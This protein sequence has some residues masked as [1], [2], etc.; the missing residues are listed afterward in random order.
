MPSPFPGMDPYIEGQGWANFHFR[1]IAS[2]S[3]ALLPVLRPRYALVIEE[4]VYLERDAESHSH[5]RPDITVVDEGGFPHG[6]ERRG[7]ATLE[8]PIIVTL[9]MPE[10]IREHYLAVRDRAAGDVIT[11][12]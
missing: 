11:V 3:D 8:K 2:I 7:V 6:G 9:P 12:I 4:R 5:T 10:E 1:F